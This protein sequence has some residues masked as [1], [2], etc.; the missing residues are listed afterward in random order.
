MHIKIDSASRETGLV[1]HATCIRLE[2]EVYSV[3]EVYLVKF[4]NYSTLV[5]NKNNR[6]FMLNTKPV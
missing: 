3:S 4:V 2:R 6:Q 1:K 5:G